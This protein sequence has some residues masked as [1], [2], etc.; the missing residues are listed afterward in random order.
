MFKDIFLVAIIFKVIFDVNYFIYYF[1]LYQHFYM[2][3]KKFKN[4]LKTFKLFVFFISLVFVIYNI[5]YWSLQMDV[6][7]NSLKRALEMDQEAVL[8]DLMTGKKITVNN[9]VSRFHTIL[10]LTYFCFN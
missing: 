3:I 5:F 9:G 10:D 8:I 1:I 7:D 6:K 4:C 2:F